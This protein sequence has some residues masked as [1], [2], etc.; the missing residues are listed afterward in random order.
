MDLENSR[1]DCE[2]DAYDAT[3]G[4]PAATTPATAHEHEPI[5]RST[6]ATSEHVTAAADVTP[7]PPASFAE[8]PAHV[9]GAVGEDGA[10]AQGAEQQGEAE[11]NVSSEVSGAGVLLLTVQ[12]ASL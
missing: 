12:P 9:D 2:A 1:H 6:P 10:V 11:D 4:H 7:L 3:G 5:S 8:K